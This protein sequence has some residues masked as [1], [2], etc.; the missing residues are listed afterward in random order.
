MGVLEVGDNCDNFVSLV[1]LSNVGPD[2]NSAFPQIFYL[3]QP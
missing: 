3:L 1:M 2:L